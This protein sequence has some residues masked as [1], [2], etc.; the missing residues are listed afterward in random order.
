MEE[1]V[2]QE[3]PSGNLRFIHLIAL[4][5][6]VVVIVM[7]GWSYLN[8][9]R[10][11]RSLA[12]VEAEIAATQ[13]DLEEMESQRLDAV[14]VAQQAVDEVDSAIAWSEVITD[15]ITVTPLD[16]FYRSYSASTD[17]K[18]SLSVLTDSYDSAAYLLSI[19]DEES[20]FTDV[21]SSSLTS[22]FSDSGF[23]VV[24]FGLTFNVQQ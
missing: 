12:S 11:N 21:F 24:S 20:M 16:V 4:L 15:L 19:L 1:D 10:L 22:G 23:D 14:V 6:L 9:Y 2:R 13:A 17:G 7:T 3:I 5:A 8:K 18:M